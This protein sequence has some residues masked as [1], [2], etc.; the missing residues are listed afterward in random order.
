MKN[1]NANKL[2]N[3]KCM[4]LGKPDCTSVDV[5]VTKTSIQFQKDHV[6]HVGEV[7]LYRCTT[8]SE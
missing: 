7:A 4:N 3:N 5:Y 6:K 8:T 1:K 2:G